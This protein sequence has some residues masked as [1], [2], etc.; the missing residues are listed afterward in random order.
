M[1]VSMIQYTLA[2]PDTNAKTRAIKTTLV[3]VP[4][5]PASCSAIITGTKAIQARGH[6]STLGMLRK[7]NRAEQS[8]RP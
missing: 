1:T 5:R 7:M 8:A 2:T 6:Q 3:K 4:E